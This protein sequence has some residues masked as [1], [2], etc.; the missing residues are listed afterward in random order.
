MAEISLPKEI[1]GLGPAIVFGNPDRGIAGTRFYLKPEAFKKYKDYTFDG[2]RLREFSMFDGTS[3]SVSGVESA[4]LKMIRNPGDK[5]GAQTS[6]TPPTELRTNPVTGEEIPL[7]NAWG[8]R[9]T[10]SKGRNVDIPIEDLT[11]EKPVPKPRKSHESRPSSTRTPREELEQIRTGSADATGITTHDNENQDNISLS[12]DG[13]TPELLH[14]GNTTPEPDIPPIPPTTSGNGSGI[15]IP[16]TPSTSQPERHTTMGLYGVKGVKERNASDLA[17]DAMEKS[18]NVLKKFF[19]E[20]FQERYDQFYRR[21][22]EAAQTPFARESIVLAQEAAQKRYQQELDSRTGLR[23]A[24][25]RFLEFVKSQTGATTLVEEYAIDEMTNL[26][27]EAIRRTV[28]AE[29]M[30]FE[31]QKQEFA[32]RFD[33]PFEAADVA[34]RKGLGER[35]EILDPNNAEHVKIIGGIKDLVKEYRDGTIDEQTLN[36]RLNALYKTQITSSRNDLFSEAETY[37]SSIT[38]VAKE[39]RDRLHHGESCA[40]LDAELQAMKIRLGIGQMGAA[41]EIN[42]TST[43][44][45]MERINR[46]VRTLEKRGIIHNVVLNEYTVGTAV[47]AV[48]ALK[49]IPQSAA[50]MTARMWIGGGAGAAVTGV[51]SG[52]REFMRRSGELRRIGAQN[53]AGITNPGTA[54]NREWYR[55]RFNFQLRNIQGNDGLIHGMESPILENGQMKQTVTTDELRGS[56]ANLADAKA[57][58]ALSQR[59]QN[60]F[61]LIILGA[62]GEQETNRTALVQSMIRTEGNLKTYLIAHRSDQVV[63]DLL[64]PTTANGT[65]ETD[66]KNYM[67]S[68]VKTQTQILTEGNDVLQRLNDPT[69]TLALDPVSRYTPEVDVMRRNF[70]L[71][72]EARSRGTE[73]GIDAILKEFRIQAGVESARTGLK[74][75]GIG[76]AIGAISNEITMDLK[77]GFGSGAISRLFVHGQ[78]SAVPLPT[79]PTHIETI[80]DH[81]ITLDESMHIDTQGNLDITDTSGHSLNDVVPN[82]TQHVKFDANGTM[83]LD[84]YAMDHLKHV[85]ITTTL[86]H[87]DAAASSL[88]LE[89]TPTQTITAPGAKTILDSGN[90]AHT[91]EWSVPQGAHF[92]TTG[93]HTYNLVAGDG[94]TITGIHTDTTGAITNYA[95]IQNRLPAGWSIHDTTSQIQHIAET[96]SMDTSTRTIH[97]FTDWDNRGEWGWIEKQLQ[98]QSMTNHNADINAIKNV[99][100]SYENLNHGTNITFD[101]TIPGLEHVQRM[102]PL[103]N[104]EVSAN[105]MPNNSLIELPNSLF[106]NEHMAQMATWS[107]QAIGMYNKLMASNPEMTP[108]AALET[109]QNQNELMGLM[110]RIGHFAVPSLGQDTLSASE[111]QFLSEQLS[112]VHT[113]TVSTILHS[114]SFGLDTTSGSSQTMVE[115]FLHVTAFAHE[116]PPDGFIP[117]LPFPEF[118][119]GLESVPSTPVTPT[120]TPPTGPSP[121]SPYGTNPYAGGQRYVSNIPISTTVADQERVKIATPILVQKAFDEWHISQDEQNTIAGWTPAEQLQWLMDE[122]NKRTP[123]PEPATTDPIQE[124]EQIAEQLHVDLPP[125]EPVSPIINPPENPPIVV[126][127]AE[128]RRIAE[129]NLF[130][131]IVSEDRSPIAPE[132]KNE[133]ITQVQSFLSIQDLDV[134]EDKGGILKKDA[135]KMYQDILTWV[136]QQNSMD[137][138]ADNPA[139]NPT[140]YAQIEIFARS[141]FWT[142]NPDARDVKQLSNALARIVGQTDA[143]YHIMNT[144]NPEITMANLAV[145]Y[146]AY[147]SMKNLPF[148]KI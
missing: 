81:K 142:T 76:L 35:Y 18:R 147:D 11:T 8:V 109:I 34:I 6:L 61:G 5:Q 108:M 51:I 42:Q 17:H 129:E 57:R 27:T 99:W 120:V 117:I 119:K 21:M 47:S 59:E 138:M 54:K 131:F 26:R 90:T 146:A 127:E 19:S 33:T 22:F 43:H 102:I 97:V 130:E 49:M 106:S 103:V 78:E 10:D 58:S 94:T 121:Y 48:L 45:M 83:S 56:L 143:A 105:V 52:R 77:S 39:M 135:P 115:N 134:A 62:V 89:H 46:T 107:E 132:G 37:A 72:G 3:A 67:D 116:A 38:V 23:R 79:G 118:R 140:V 30:G 40:V 124:I 88:S 87:T 12:D 20:Y 85:G 110:L 125:E 4:R 32:A 16:L 63:I 101:H 69:I 73:Q 128:Q 112:G 86:G 113:E 139:F 141:T 123:N 148:R 133:A 50:S 82:F 136:S 24:G 55:Q 70:L 145:V 25:R 80:G 66:V 137:I 36:D 91:P 53:E 71:W 74:S 60:R 2:K 92:V 144:A 41:T 65:P 126:D 75:A 122:T 96:G 64:G 111:L 29:R 114:I 44:K 98:G 84:T 1:P 104:G 7:K 13:T 93:D 9:M 14:I 15:P 68:L 31:N 95:D 28:T 100:Q